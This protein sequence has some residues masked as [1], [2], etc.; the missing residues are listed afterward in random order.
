MGSSLSHSTSSNSPTNCENVTGN[1]NDLRK[2]AQE[3][4]N[5]KMNSKNDVKVDANL[6]IKS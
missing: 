5:M 3:H 4:R 1:Q 2:A 6:P